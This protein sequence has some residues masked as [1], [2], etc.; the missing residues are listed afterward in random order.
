MPNHPLKCTNCNDFKKI[1]IIWVRFEEEIGKQIDL[2][3][4]F[5]IC[6]NCGDKK[7]HCGQ[8]FYE[9]LVKEEF[10]KMA[11]NEQKDLLFKY[12]TQEFPYY[13]KLNFKYSPEDYFLIP[14]LS[15]PENDGYLIPVFFDKDVLLYYNNH[16][17]YTVRFGSFSSGNIYFKGEPLFSWGFGINR[18][19]KIFMWLGDLYEDLGGKE[20]ESHL[21]R[22]QA[23][24]VISDHD[25]YSKFYLM[26][27]Q[28]V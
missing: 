11:D 17:D 5:Y 8:E 20:M 2:N 26:Q 23:S 21:K 6:P 13:S 16:P 27:N 9:K 15:R 18:N 7:P 19:D 10:L 12:E 1:K 22:F 4:P 3:I 24:N 25:V 14:G 28:T